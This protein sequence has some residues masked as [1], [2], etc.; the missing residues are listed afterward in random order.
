M[1]DQLQLGKPKGES[2]EPKKEQLETDKPKGEHEKPNQKQLEDEKSKGSCGDSQKQ[3]DD[4][5]EDKSSRKQQL[6]MDEGTFAT[7][8]FRQNS[9]F[10]GLISRLSGWVEEIFLDYSKT[11]GYFFLML[12]KV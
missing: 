12:T 10:G 5:T 11:L 8:H 2:Q 1:K 3:G 9:S 6:I 7:L 4:S